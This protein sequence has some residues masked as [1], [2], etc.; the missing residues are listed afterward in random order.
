MTDTT[1]AIRIR[2]G[3]PADV[4][5]VLNMLDAAVVWMNERGNTEQ[6]GT[7][8]IRRSPAGCYGS[9]GT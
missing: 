5:A 6:W 1:H 4:P 2:P 3:G 7:T 8:P 9:S